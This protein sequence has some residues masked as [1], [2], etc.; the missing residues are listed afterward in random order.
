VFHLLCVAFFVLWFVN[1]VLHFVC[2]ALCLVFHFVLIGS[3]VWCAILDCVFLGHGCRPRWCAVRHTPV[4]QCV[5]VCSS[6]LQCVAVCCSVL[7]SV[8]VC[9]SVLQCVA[10]YCSVLQCVAVCSSVLQ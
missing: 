10:L 4:L 7:Q 8:A 1:S 2:S 9:C 6:V 3:G 5:A